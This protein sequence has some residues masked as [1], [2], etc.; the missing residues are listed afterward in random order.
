MKSQRI[1]IAGAGI[2]GLAL[3]AALQRTGHDPLVLERAPRIGEVGAGL[4]LLPGAM[5]ALAAIG[6]SRA[7]LARASPLR[8]LRIASRRGAELAHVDFDALFARVRGEGYVAHRADLHAALAACVD[9]ARIRTGC[10]VAGFAQDERGV[11]VRV[12]GAEDEISGDL[13]V[14]ADGL[15]SAVREQLLG[16]GLPHYAGETL[17]RGVALASHGDPAL[18]CE[19]IGAGQRAAFYALGP[20]RWYWW[21]AVPLSEGSA[22][23]QG[24]RGALLAR[25]FAGWPFGL[26]ELLARTPSDEILQNDSCDRPPARTWH[27]GRVALL[28]DAA[29][30][31]TPNLGQG[32]CM[33]LEDAVVLARAIALAETPEEAFAGFRRARAGPAAQ[34]TRLSRRWGRVGLWRSGPAERL[35]DAAYALTPASWLAAILR[36]QYDYDPGTLPD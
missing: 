18:C 23:P 4:G 13:L 16:D 31:T 29:H 11:R 1:L 17:F 36:R 3:A 34:I 35:R 32:A 27:R 6:V 26:P 25:H 2:G 10:T 20:G 15:R 24:E 22:I 9:P 33:A 14:G 12:E 8:R 30:P 28:G 7:F 21:A 19:M 5:R